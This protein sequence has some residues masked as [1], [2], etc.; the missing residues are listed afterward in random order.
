MKLKNAFKEIR[1]GYNINNSKVIDE[2]S[3]KI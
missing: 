2:N 1:N 3:K